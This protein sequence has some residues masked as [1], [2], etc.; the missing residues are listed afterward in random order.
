MCDIQTQCPDCN[1]RYLVSPTQLSIAAGMVCCPK[2]EYHFNAYGSLKYPTHTQTEHNHQNVNLSHH[3]IHER[4]SETAILSIFE[5]KLDSSSVDLLNYLN[6]YR[7]NEDHGLQFIQ[8]DSFFSFSKNP[9]TKLVNFTIHVFLLML[10]LLLFGLVI[11][12]ITNNNSG[13]KQQ[14]P[15][16]ANF[17]I[18]TC[19]LVKC[20]TQT[21]DELKIEATRIHQDYPNLTTITGKFVNYSD[22]PQSLPHLQVITTQKIFD[23]TPKLYLLPS[24]QNQQHIATQQ[25]LFFRIDVP[26]NSVNQQ[27]KLKLK[28][29]LN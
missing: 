7:F 12:Q 4:G 15:I 26:L 5:R 23:F 3:R 28:K 8:D 18:Q 1:T 13:L 16:L 19:N 17:S 24:Q 22:H 14:F 21:G 27:F 29:S 6:S 10:N 20:S 9:S 2:C 11:S 25:A